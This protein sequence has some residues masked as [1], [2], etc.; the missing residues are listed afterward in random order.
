[1]AA[2]HG[3]IQEDDAGQILLAYMEPKGDKWQIRADFRSHNNHENWTLDVICLKDE[4][5]SLYERPPWIYRHYPNLGDN[6]RYN[7]GIGSDYV[8]GIVGMAA[9]NGDINEDGAGPIL[10]TFMYEQGGEWCIRADFR[11]HNHHENWDINVLCV[12]TAI[13]KK[14]W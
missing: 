14:W 12:S 1:M 6:V 11:S 9:W 5:E 10:R 2:Y 3:D 7:T 13:A 8:C 4:P